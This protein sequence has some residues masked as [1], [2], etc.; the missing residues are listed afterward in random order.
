MSGCLQV[1]RFYQYR[2]FI[3]HTVFLYYDLAWTTFKL[4]DY[5]LFEMTSQK[6]AAMLVHL[7]SLTVSI[8]LT[9]PACSFYIVIGKDSP[10][11]EQSHE[12]LPQQEPAKVITAKWVTA[13]IP[14][15][16]LILHK[17]EVYWEH[18]N[19]LLI[20]PSPLSVMTACSEHR[21][22]HGNPMV[23]HFVPLEPTFA[24]GGGS[25]RLYNS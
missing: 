3:N 14:R 25:Q 2:Q 7:M 22:Q 15:T 13:V 24:S 18:P 5:K 21:A 1:N 4:P 10:C 23:R 6:R 12:V 9:L 19:S 17:S 16:I 20:L 11:K 8:Q